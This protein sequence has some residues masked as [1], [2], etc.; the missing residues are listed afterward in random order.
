MVSASGARSRN[1]S[2]A[3]VETRVF[4]RPPP[5][6]L[7]RQMILRIMKELEPSLGTAPAAARPLVV[8]PRTARVVHAEPNVFLTP[9]ATA[10]HPPAPWA[11]P[12]EE[13]GNRLRVVRQRSK[14]PWFVGVMSFALAFGILF[15]P[16]VR[17]QTSS[18]IKTAAASVYQYSHGAI[19]R[20]R[21]K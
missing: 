20:V 21:S 6:G 19:A 2:D 7:D 16:V 12:V 18:Q 5:F 14:L 11:N 13:S 17:R 15:D 4:A 9:W 8:P 1:D 3:D 10:D